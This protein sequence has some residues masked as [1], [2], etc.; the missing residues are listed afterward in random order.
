MLQDLS[1]TIK[2]GKYAHKPLFLCKKG[3]SIMRINRFLF[4]QKVNIN[5]CYKF[6][7][8][9]AYILRPCVGAYIIVASKFAE[10]GLATSIMGLF[11]V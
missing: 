6:H 1:F 7:L 2:C 8:N 5:I 9:P 10:N 11:W 3:E 4:I